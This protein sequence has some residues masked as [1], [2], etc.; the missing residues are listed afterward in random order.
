MNSENSAVKKTKKK[1][2]NPFRYFFFDFVKVTGCWTAALWLRPKRLFE[3][4]KAKKHVR[5][6]AVLIANHTG[7]TDPISVHLALWY[8]RMHSLATT[9]LYEQK[10][11][12]WFF[13]RMHCIPVDRENFS[14]ETYRA[15]M[16]TLAERKILCIFPEGAINFGD[17]S[18][19]NSFKSGAVLMA[20]KG[21]APIV[22]VYIA[23][24]KKWYDRTVT[25]IGEPIDVAAL[26][27]ERPN[28][29]TIE[30][31][32]QDIHEKETKLMEIYQAWKTKK[33]S[34]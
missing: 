34:K 20:L 6:R 17:K 24:R 14:M 32:T 9:E 7:F 27:G 16:E 28:L 3:S 19:V 21:K 12:A 13:T 23:P 8:R 25:V 2:R 26:C 1:R 5:G 15:C 31:V 4:K 22:P 11:R 10:S 33:S 29:A 18:K 30:Q